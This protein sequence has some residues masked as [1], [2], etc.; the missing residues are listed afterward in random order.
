[1]EENE[2]IFDKI[3]ELLGSL[4]SQLK[5]L[6]EK[7][8]I[9]VQLEYFECSRRVRNKL[10]QEKTLYNSVRLFIDETPHEEKKILLASLASISKVESFRILEKFL[11][12]DPGD[13]KAWAILALQE[14]RMLLESVLLDESHVFISTGLGGKGEKLRYFIVLFGKDK[15]DFT[16]LHMKIIRNELEICLKKYNSEIE[17]LNFSGCLANLMAVIPMKVIIKQIFDEAISECNE[18]GNF[19]LPNFIITNVKELSFDEIRE[20]IRSQD[21]LNKVNDKT[22]EDK[23]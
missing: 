7:I 9:D 2:N 12:G 15:N 19:L 16:D 22:I 3:K 5:V 21:L 8:D 20:Y 17:E 11:N 1:M 18:Y 14:N 4:P 6:E 23:D 13:L 10:N